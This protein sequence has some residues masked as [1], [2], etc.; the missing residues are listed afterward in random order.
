M[1]FMLSENMLFFYRMHYDATD[2][3][4]STTPAI[5]YDATDPPPKIRTCISGALKNGATCVRALFLVD[6]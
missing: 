6:I 5:R 4:P 1:L 2:P 3:P